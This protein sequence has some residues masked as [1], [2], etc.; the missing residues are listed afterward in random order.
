MGMGMG[1]QP[2]TL[3]YV[4]SSAGIYGSDMILL[5]M[6]GRLDRSH[7]QPIVILPTEGPLVG[8]LRGMGIEVLVRPLSVIHRTYALTFWLRFVANLWCSSRWMRNLIRTRGVGLVHSNTSHVLNG[9]LAAR[10]AGVPHVWHV[11]E[12]RG[13]GSPVGRVLERMLYALSDR[14]LVVSNA[15][16]CTVFSSLRRDDPRIA[17]VLDGIEVSRFTSVE[18]G[19]RVR[20]ELGIEKEIPTVGVVGRITGW[21]G[22][23]LF[24][25]AAVQ[26]HARLPKVRFLIVGDAVTSGDLQVRQALHRQVARLGLQDAVIFTGVRD[27]IP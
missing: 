3:L 7:Y 5:H 4:H 18:S 24:L 14:I 2:V 10:W 9:A 21:K 8:R 19:D 20:A 13:A 26:V 27:D 25:D 17:V 6:V 12:M 11:R 22:H 16:R 1:E 23:N 15:V